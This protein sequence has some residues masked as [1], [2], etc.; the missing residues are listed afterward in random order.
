MRFAILLAA[1]GLSACAVAADR[2]AEAGAAEDSVLSEALAGRVAGAP[3]SCVR[4]QD[5]RN[6]RG[7]GPDTILFDGPGNVLYVNR[8]RSA[9]PR[10]LASHAI[11]NR[12]IGTSLCS[13]E[14]IRIFDPQNG[15][16]FGGCTLGAFTPWRRA[17]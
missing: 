8:T 13:G 10:I 1:A 9:C 4:R 6:T 3:V 14:L 2:P 12:S 7:A 5:V 16:E 17:G 11:R 15:I